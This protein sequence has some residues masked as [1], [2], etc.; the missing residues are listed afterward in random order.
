M[1]E[2]FE[3][4]TEQ[5]WREAF[6]CLRGLRPN[7]KLESFLTNRQNL[8][9]RDYHLFGLM[10]DGRIV[11]VAGY[12]LQPHIERGVEFWLHDFATLETERSKGHGLK[13]ISHLEKI[14]EQHGCKRLVLHT[15]LDRKLAQKFY[16]SKAGYS[17]YAL[18]YSKE[19]SDL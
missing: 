11:C 17:Q 18:V 16:E 4:T 10:Q 5:E 9:D 1:A 2:I 13:M 8:I 12:V 6:E 19:L 15:R 7:L 3:L 14:A